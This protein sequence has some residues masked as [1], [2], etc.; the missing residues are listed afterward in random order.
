LK[1]V[2]SFR[3]VGKILGQ[4]I[5]KALV[6]EHLD[7]SNNPLTAEDIVDLLDS[8]SVSTSLKN[9]GITHVLVDEQLEKVFA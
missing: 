8:I 7:I 2:D 5:K 9:L 4:G 6:L 3:D 1:F